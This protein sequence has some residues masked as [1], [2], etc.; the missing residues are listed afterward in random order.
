MVFL[1]LHSTN[2]AT[3][4]L[5]PYLCPEGQINAVATDP[6]S[7][8]DNRVT[9]TTAVRLLMVEDCLP[10]FRLV[11]KHCAEFKDHREWTVELLKLFINS[12]F[13]LEVE[14]TFFD[15]TNCKLL[16]QGHFL[17]CALSLKICVN[18][19]SHLPS[20]LF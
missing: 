6:F 20:L 1:P 15:L 17:H 14:V 4:R 2:V 7:F 3:V 13:S 12:S 8:T 10:F 16:L 11:K 18:A 19:N 9:P 5:F